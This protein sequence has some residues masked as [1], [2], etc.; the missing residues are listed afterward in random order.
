MWKE[1]KQFAIR[2]NVIELAIAVILGTA[3]TKIIDT[4]VKDLFMPVLGMVIGNVDF[5]YIR[6]V[7]HGQEI[8]IG[9]LLQVTVEFLFIA[10]ALFIVVRGINRVKRRI[11]QQEHIAD[12]S[13]LDIL[14]EI[15]DILA[16]QNNSKKLP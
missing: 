1:F 2:G 16:E 10:F 15:R 5:T 6:I 4:I 9:N 12:K 11:G 13:Q 8:F 3:F 7:F 14:L